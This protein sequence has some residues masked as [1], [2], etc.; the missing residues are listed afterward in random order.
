VESI[1]G[2]NK[3]EDLTSM[4][5]SLEKTTED[6]DKLISILKY[7]K[8]QELTYEEVKNS[9]LGKSISKLTKNTNKEVSTISNEI[10]NKWRKL[11]KP[12]ENSKS[13]N[14]KKKWYGFRGWKLF[15][16]IEIVRKYKSDEKK[17]NQ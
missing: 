16:N 9:K 2:S 1:K 4:R 13:N 6:V 3:L 8:Q 17:K 10:V 12:T 15:K 5:L 11:D 14:T 7:L